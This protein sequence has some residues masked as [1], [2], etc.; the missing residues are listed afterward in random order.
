MSINDKNSFHNS[1]NISNMFSNLILQI[2]ISKYY[3]FR[4]NVFHWKKNPLLC[5]SLFSPVG[6]V[7]EQWTVDESKRLN[8]NIVEILTKF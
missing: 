6:N 1:E 7:C 2:R 8:W 3:H 5:L 4:V